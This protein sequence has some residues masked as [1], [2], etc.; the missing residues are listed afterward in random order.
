MVIYALLKDTNKASLQD[1]IVL[2]GTEYGSGS[3]RDWAAK[4]PMLLGVKSM[5]LKVLREFIIERYTINLPS[6]ITEIKP[7]QD[8]K[9]VTDSGKSF[10]C[11]A[12][13]NTKGRS[14]GP[15]KP[16]A[17]PGSFSCNFKPQYTFKFSL[18]IYNFRSYSQ[19][20][21]RNAFTA[22]ELVILLPLPLFRNS[23]ATCS[24]KCIG[25]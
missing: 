18:T 17:F 14:Q 13:F 23:H 6:K 12:R 19:I 4:G 20:V 10:T 15:A 1:T 2:E 22:H 9:V 7:G 8:I 3:S 5:K 21:R 16:G 24:M 25:C 11:I